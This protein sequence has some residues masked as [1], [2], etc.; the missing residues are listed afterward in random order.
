MEQNAPPALIMLVD[1]AN[2]DGPKQI[3]ADACVVGGGAAGVALARQLLAGGL[4]VCLLEAGGSDFE[5]A[6]QDLYQ[7]D[8]VGMPYYPIRESRLRF[9]GGTTNIWGGRCVPMQPL[10]FVRRDWVP[11]SGWPITYE[12]LVPHYRRAHAALEL[13]EYRY[14]DQ[15][16]SLSRHKSPE[17][18]AELFNTLFWRFDVKAER[19]GRD[20]LDRLASE[21]RCQCVLHAN[22]TRIQARGNGTAVDHLVA[23]S[24]T[25][26]RINVA[27]KHYVLAC[28]AIENARLLLASNDVQ[29]AGV[30]NAHDQVGRYFMEHPHAR[31]ATLRTDSGTSAS[32]RTGAFAL[33]RAYA[34]Q[35][36]TVP[37][38][39]VLVPSPRLQQREGLLN[40]A[41][42]FKLQRD[43]QLGTPMNRR[44]YLSLK[45]DLNPTRQGRALWQVYRQGKSLLQ[46]TVR[47]RFEQAR[48][49]LGLTGL[50]VMVRAEQAPNPASRVQLSQQRDALGQPLADLNWQLGELDKRTLIGLAQALGTEMNRLRLGQ[51]N[52]SPWLA[53]DGLRWP[54]DDSIGNH[55]IGGYH[56]MGTTRMSASPAHGVV[57]ANCRVHGY[58]D[59][60]VAGSSVFTTGGWA[61][62][63]LT[64]LALT[65]RL[66]THLLSR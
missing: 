21:P 5:E 29:Q 47:H 52:T 13:G 24:L 31:I 3:A 66:G 8:N 36:S 26:K 60:Y 12:D 43:E 57:D 38:A 63:T 9:F 49:A 58:E 11:H 15:L 32:S 1:L 19:F 10:D 44:V 46:R 59:L 33:W 34:K 23:Q 37:I 35:F 2:Y 25:G 51:L 4:S 30:G 50:H 45:H 39:P 54:V 22:V 7:G 56:H 55:P 62:P 16:W 40:T 27:A 6:T 18:A 14:D 65:D 64:L 17:F 61:N 28:G 41:L 20:M 42:T 53:E 48:V